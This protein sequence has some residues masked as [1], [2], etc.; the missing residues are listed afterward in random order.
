MQRFPENSWLGLEAALKAGACWIEFDVQ[1]CGDGTFILL[2]DDNFERTAT[3]R[4]SVFDTGKQQIKTISVHEPKRFGNTYS[5]TGVPTLETVLENISVFPD[6]RAMVEIK[7]A[8]LDHWGMG[9]VMDALLQMLSPLQRQCVLISYS[10]QALNYAKKH[11]SL[12]TGWVLSLYDRQH[13]N[14]ARLLE[15]R[16]LICNQRKIP[17]TEIPW[18][19]PWCW[20]LYDINDPQVALR[21]ASRGVDLIESRDIGT[22]LKHPELSREAC[23]HDL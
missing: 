16:F 23:P 11:S 21:W 13:L 19:G 5:P 3:R 9:K 12:D 22:M 7:Q 18:P 4:Q 17:P 10:L 2:H 15:P 6:A 14:Q 20:M 1:M 8:S